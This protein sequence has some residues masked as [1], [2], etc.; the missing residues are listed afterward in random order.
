MRFRLALALIVAVAAIFHVEPAVA[1]YAPPAKDARWF[2][3]H[4]G[5]ETCV[6][7]DDVGPDLSRLYYGAGNMHTPEDFVAVALSRGIRNA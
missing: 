2:V 5:E 4:L 1:Q 7:L 3:G 6:P